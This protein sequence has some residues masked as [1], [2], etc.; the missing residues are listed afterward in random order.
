MIR[1]STALL[2]VISFLPALGL[3]LLLNA[4]VSIWSYPVRAQSVCQADTLLVMGAAQY[5]GVP[6]PVFKRRLDTAL[7]L[8]GSGCADSILVTGGRQQGDAYSEG[9][10]GARY[11]LE[12]GVPKDALLGDA[13][14]HELRESRVRPVAPDGRAGAHRDGRHA[15]LPQP[16]A[17]KAPGHR[18]ARVAGAYRACVALQSQ[19]DD[20]HISLSLRDD[21]VGKGMRFQF[22]I[23][24]HYDL[25]LPEGA[26][27]PLLV[28]LHGYGQDKDAA[29]Q[30]G[31][32]SRDDWPVAA[33]QAPHPHHVGYAPGQRRTG[34]SWV[35]DF[36]PHEDIRNHHLFVRSIIEKAYAQ[37][38]TAEPCAYLFGFSQSVSLNYRFAVAQPRFVKGIIAVAGATPSD[39]PAPPRPGPTLQMPVLHIAP[40][41]DEA[42]PKERAQSFR[43]Q[44]EARASRLTWLE[45][46]GGHRVPRVAYPQIR[47]WLEAQ[48]KG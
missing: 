17:G 14:P 44:L 40:A 47:A 45:P 22:P 23:S 28:C 12:Q 29:M 32:R 35:S 16:L 30:Y 8:Y 46:P 1:A 11:L 26:R 20:G 10:A 31:K 27:R 37:G 38:W 2:H 15:R 41:D 34:F 42:Y 6:S 4:A 7:E 48:E 24:Y 3:F 25:H 19:G 5:N 9:E 39:W 33:L 43:Q 21:Q 36:E 18:C 13:Q